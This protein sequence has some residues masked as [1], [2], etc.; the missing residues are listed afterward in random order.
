MLVILS[1]LLLLITVPVSAQGLLPD[2]RNKFPVTGMPSEANDALPMAH[3][4]ATTHAPAGYLNACANITAYGGAGDGVTDNIAAWTAA[5]EENKF[6]PCIYFPRGQYIFTD[7]VAFS[8]TSSA[9]TVSIIGDGP[10]ASELIWPTGGGISLTL[11]AAQNAFHIHDVSI[12][13]GAANTGIGLSI[14]QTPHTDY[15]AS[16]TIDRVKISGA[17]NVTTYW[18][19]GI[20]IN[21]HSQVNIS[22]LD[23]YEN[24]NGAR[25]NGIGLDLEAP[26][27]NLSFIYNIVNS[28]FFGAARG[29]VYGANVQGLSIVSCNFT[30]NVIGIDIPANSTNQAQLSIVNSQFDNAGDNILF[31]SGTTFPHIQINNNLFFLVANTAGIHAVSLGQYAMLS[32]NEFVTTTAALLA[33]SQGIRIDANTAGGNIA[34]HNLCVLL[35]TCIQLG[36]GS[37]DWLVT[38]T[39]CDGCTKIVTNAATTSAAGRN[40]IKGWYPAQSNGVSA[41]PII[42]AED[43]GS[44]LV[45]ITISST[46]NFVSGQVVLV[47]GVGG[48]AAANGVW[49]VIVVDGAHLDLISSAFA[50]SFSDSAGTVSQLP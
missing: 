10:D 21:S 44:G 18:A 8:E 11:N 14:S 32:H 46:S 12:K 50:G 49:P 7:Q 31:E 15:I 13:T 47:Q 20:K 45:R 41:V 3:H 37:L 29:I 27:N 5:L 22:S 24:D 26:S 34:D 9:K 43:N 36:T 42:G 30:L 39:R 23:I 48:V 38:D 4:R 2:I 17:T 40:V 28:N 6:N 16:S 35:V 19:T 1:F 33:G 25:S